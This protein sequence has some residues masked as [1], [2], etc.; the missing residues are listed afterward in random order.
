[1]CVYPYHVNPA[2]LKDKLARELVLDLARAY[3]K[4][5]EAS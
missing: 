4:A 1:M 2:Q 3:S 5:Y